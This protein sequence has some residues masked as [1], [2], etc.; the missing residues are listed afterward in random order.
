[1][2]SKEPDKKLESKPQSHHVG[3]AHGPRESWSR[4]KI[5]IDAQ[6]G[7]IYEANFSESVSSA[8]KW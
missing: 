6:C 3:K 8:I 2:K 1:M 5:N 4:L 7:D